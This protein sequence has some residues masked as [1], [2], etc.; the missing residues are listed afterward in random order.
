MITSSIHRMEADYL[1][2]IHKAS[3]YELEKGLEHDLVLKTDLSFN[4]TGW[5]AAAEIVHGR[6]GAMGRNLFELVDIGFIDGSREELAEKLAKAGCWT[7]EVNFNRFDGS[8]LIFKTTATYIIDEHA[9]PVSI[10]IICHNISDSKRKE[11]ELAAAESKYEILMNTIQQGVIMIDRHFRITACNRRGTDIIGIGMDE[12]MQLDLSNS[13]F[14]VVRA[15]GSPMHFAEF[16]AIVS[17]QTGFPQRNVIMGIIRS[18]GLV[19][20]ISVNSE[21]LIHPGD[22]EPYAAVCSFADITESVY[23]E[24]ELKKSNERF[25]YASQITTDAIWDVD[26][27]TMEIYRSDAFSRLS[28]YGREEIGNNLD[29]WFT[30]I[31]PDERGRVRRKVNEHI[32]QGLERWEDEYRFECANGEFKSFCDS[33]IILYRNSKPIR[34]LGAIRDVTEQKLLEKQLLREQAERH[35]AITQASLEAQEREKAHISRELH[36]NVNQ[37]LMSAKLFM[38]TVKRLPQETPILIDKAIE[39][40]LLAL[41]EI[42]K[43]SRNLST[44]HVKAAG[45][46]ESVTDIIENLRLLN[47]EVD[48]VYDDHL[49]K[50]LGDAQSLMMFR[51][52]QEQ[53]NNIIKYARAGKVWITICESGGLV[54]LEVRDDGVGFDNSQRSDK[55]IGFINIS[56]RAEIYN[57]RVSISSAPGEGCTLGL[58]FPLNS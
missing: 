58:V 31:H 21:A 3:V 29:W 44:S 7:G 54:R 50:K 47:M 35:K 13:G 38:D 14:R 39:Y 8:Q 41:Q 6:P 10:L 36:D 57:G 42:R 18:E 5:N 28:G 34:I 25:Y 46:R 48:F 2:V 20:W 9:R 40:Q 55:G 23:T 32:E 24:R 11:K 15:D 4:I 27:E 26:L 16:P 19:T 56:S 33:G 52:I 37:I 53:T 12:I 45:L 17:L 1:S 51:V 49:E 22:F 30:K 43:L